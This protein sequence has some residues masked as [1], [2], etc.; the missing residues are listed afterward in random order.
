MA[1]KASDAA[2]SLCATATTFEDKQLIPELS[3]AAQ[4]T[5]PSKHLKT[6]MS[7]LPQTSR[8]VQNRKR[9]SILDDSVPSCS[10]DAVSMPPASKRKRMGTIPET[11]PEETP[12]ECA[13]NC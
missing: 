8:S 7:Q 6:S 10:I 1:G 12:E 2:A 3:E 11:I 13:E 5:V 9:K 4:A